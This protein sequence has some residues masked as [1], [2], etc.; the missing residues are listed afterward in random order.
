MELRIPRRIT[1]PA[2]QFTDSRFINLQ[3]TVEMNTTDKENVQ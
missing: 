1:D 3:F 2:N